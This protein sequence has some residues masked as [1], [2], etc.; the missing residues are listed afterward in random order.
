[1]VDVGADASPGVPGPPLDPKQ[2]S[3]AAPEPRPRPEHSS[4]PAE[5]VHPLLRTDTEPPWFVGLGRIEIEKKLKTKSFGE[6]KEIAAEH[7]RSV[8]Q[9][10]MVT[11]DRASFREALCDALLEDHDGE[12]YECDPVP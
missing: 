7:A 6:L 9:N 11:S 4:L 12:L 5:A 3:T 8:L 1:M 2:D 10:R